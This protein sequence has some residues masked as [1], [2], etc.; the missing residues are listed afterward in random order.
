MDIGLTVLV[1]T[2]VIVSG[3]AVLHCIK[4]FI[5]EIKNR[6]YRRN[7]DEIHE[8]FKRIENFKL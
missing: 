3:A 8:F 5:E 6:K 4:E 2:A 7:N 1:G